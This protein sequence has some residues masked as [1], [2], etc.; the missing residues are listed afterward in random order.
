LASR[1]DFECKDILT[2]WG[3]DMEWPKSFP[4]LAIRHDHF[5]V[6]KHLSKIVQPV[7]IEIVFLFDNLYAFT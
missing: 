3:I 6:H 1:G 7:T 2:G 5:I 4:Q